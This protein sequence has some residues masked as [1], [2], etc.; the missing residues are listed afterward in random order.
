MLVL[1]HPSMDSLL[2][3]HSSSRPGP[4]L[5]LFGLAQAGFL[6]TL[7]VADCAL[8]DFLLFVQ[9]FARPELA[10]LAFDLLHLESALFVKSSSCF[11]LALFTLDSTRLDLFT[12]V[13]SLT[14]LE[15]SVSAIG[16]M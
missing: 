7:S 16:L 4:T 8:F 9:S 2:F 1:N 15:L 10:M 5:S 13:R 14:K 3:L 12:P 6:F 11:G